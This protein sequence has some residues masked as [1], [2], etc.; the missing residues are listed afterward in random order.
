M[1]KLRHFKRRKCRKWRKVLEER[2][3]RISGL[4]TL[5]LPFITEPTPSMPFQSRAKSQPLESILVLLSNGMT[6]GGAEKSVSERK[7]GGL[8]GKL[9]YK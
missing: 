6:L 4:S 8:T 7:E 9:L 1:G 5:A 2:F 3:E